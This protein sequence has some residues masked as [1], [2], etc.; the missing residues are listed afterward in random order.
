LLYINAAIALLLG[1]ARLLSMSQTTPGS[2]LT[3]WIIA[4]LMAGNMGIMLLCGWGLGTGRRWFYF[5]AVVVL[6]VNI[7]L[8]LHRPVQQ[9]C[10]PHAGHRPEH[11]GCVDHQ[12]GPI[13]TSSLDTSRRVDEFLN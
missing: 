6:A 10:S 2:S 3:Q 7:I 5:L 11:S 13:L 12:S 9:A 4:I 1:G 8:T